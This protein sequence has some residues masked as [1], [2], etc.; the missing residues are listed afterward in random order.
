[1]VGLLLQRNRSLRLV[2]EPDLGQQKS[3]LE[4]FG[5]VGVLLPLRSALMV[6][7]ESARAAAWSRLEREL[8]MSVGL[9]GFGCFQDRRASLATR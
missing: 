3:L 8:S 4:P 2:E 5:S 6:S 7:G 1:M 9:C